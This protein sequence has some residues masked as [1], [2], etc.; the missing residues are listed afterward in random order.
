MNIEVNLNVP[1]YFETPDILFYSAHF[2]K[3]IYGLL[4]FLLISIGTHKC[5]LFFAIVYISP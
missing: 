1:T 4:T 5:K 3:L 2:L